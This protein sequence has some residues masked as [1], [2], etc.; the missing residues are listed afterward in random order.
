[1][2]GSKLTHVNKKL[3]PTKILPQLGHRRHTLMG[4][5]GFKKQCSRSSPSLKKMDYI[6][7]CQ[8]CAWDP[9]HTILWAS[10]Y[11]WTILLIADIN[12]NPGKVHWSAHIIRFLC[13]V[14][15]ILQSLNNSM[16][17]SSSSHLSTLLISFNFA[18][19]VCDMARNSKWIMEFCIDPWIIRAH[20]FLKIVTC[21]PTY[22]K[23]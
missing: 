18:Q 19:P 9:P 14:I 10:M 4:D 7:C 13:N 6:I 8:L 20:S 11:L 17:A 2:L 5:N 3:L 15:S 16:H 21:N 23:S 12:D 1:M 22:D